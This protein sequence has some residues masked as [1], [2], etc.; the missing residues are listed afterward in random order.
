[1][2]NT[3]ATHPPSGLSPK[4]MVFLTAATAALGG[5]LFGYD[6]A[7]ISGAQLFFKS[8]FHLS[9]TQ[10]ELAVGVVLLGA[11]LGAALGGW[12][13]D[14][15][16]RKSVLL[17][18]G[19]CFGVFSLWTGLSTGLATFVAA[20]FLVGACIGVAS[21]LTPLY[22]SEMSPARIRGALVSLNQLAI[23]VGIV[24]A[25][26]VD[27]ALAARQ[28]WR[29]M[30][31]SAVLPAIVLVTGMLFLP[32]SP[33]W[34][35]KKGRREDALNNFR[36]LGREDEAQQELADVERVLREETGKFSELFRPGFRIAVWIGVGLA[37]FQQITG[38]NTIIYYAP[39]ILR[40][41]GFSS[42][43][44]AILGTV[45]IGV[46]NVLATVVS[47][48]L[49]D[50]LGRKPL[51]L[52]GCL[53]QAAM[54]GYVGYSFAHHRHGLAVFAGV[55]LYI[56]FFA[57]SLGPVVW[58]MLSEIYPTK[59]RGAAMSLAT[60]ANWFA[61]WVVTVTFLSLLDKLGS[62]HTFWLF[63][64]LSIAAMLF[65]LWLVPETKGRSLE[66][67]EES[68]RHLGRAKA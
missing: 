17:A 67:I 36:R 1:M 21:M 3:T 59:I 25:Y 62:V 22:I 61:N 16:G 19:V 57:I 24:V 29:M 31:I 20:R 41:A 13:T 11:M 54:L 42:A 14:R 40:N 53:G 30:F 15:L 2:P 28:D 48:L 52:I 50:R 18:T 51:L 43:R 49:I 37:V 56:V 8:S 45:G 26:G 32:E 10:L 5:L 46:V 38:I 47:I 58:L 55:L 4:A 65:C 63:A 12:L 66:E 64:I 23:T 68:F 44:V 39:T 35:A 27:Y 34:L 9:D 7:V 33:R 6:T 60:F